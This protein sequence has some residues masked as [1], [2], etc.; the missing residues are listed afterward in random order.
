MITKILFLIRALFNPDLT[1]GLMLIHEIDSQGQVIAD[2]K[3]DRIIYANKAFLKHIGR[4]IK[5]MRSKPFIDF[6]SDQ[7]KG[8]TMKA[9][10]DLVHGMTVYDF[11]NAY[12]RPDGSDAYLKWRAIVFGGLYACN[13]ELI[14]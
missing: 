11:E 10:D 5:E 4:S 7:Y 1:F 14:K 6:V 8:K 3:T 9:S 2:V 13:V 12:Q